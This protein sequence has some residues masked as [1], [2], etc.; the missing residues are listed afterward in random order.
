MLML[1]SHAGRLHNLQGHWHTGGGDR[2][3]GISGGVGAVTYFKL[4]MGAHGF[5]GSGRLDGD[6]GEARCVSAKALANVWRR[7]EAVY[8]TMVILPVSCR[9]PTRRW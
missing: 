6:E 4:A 7:A 2:A 3:H 9:D 8:L 1:T 5:K